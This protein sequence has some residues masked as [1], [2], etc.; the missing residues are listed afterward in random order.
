MGP[1]FQRTTLMGANGTSQP[2]QLAPAWQHR[3]PETDVIVE[4]TLVS[5]ATA[6]EYEITSG[7]EALVQRSNVPGGGTL[8]VYPD[9]DN[10]KKAIVAFAGRELAVTIFNTAATTP[11]LMLEIALTPV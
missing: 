7:S 11:S 6:Q 1:V 3:F 8:G 2:L 4:Y 10:V 5:T 9:F